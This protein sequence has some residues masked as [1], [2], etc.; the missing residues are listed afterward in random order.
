MAIPF[1]FVD[2]MSPEDVIPRW[3]SKHY[4]RLSKT[5]GL[6]KQTAMHHDGSQYI[7]DSQRFNVMADVVCR[8]CNTGW[9]SGLERAIQEILLTPSGSTILTDVEHLTFAD[10]MTMKSIVLELAE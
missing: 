4:K 6:I 9:M 3:F 2:E 7:L 10:W 8:P 5:K 1:A